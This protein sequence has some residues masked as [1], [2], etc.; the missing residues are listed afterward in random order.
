MTCKETQSL[1]MPY[2]HQELTDEKM[3][4]FLEHIETCKDCKE[5]LEIYYTVEVGIRQLDTDNG[6]YNIKGTMESDIF[7]SKQRLATLRIL[8]IIRYS[9]DTL[10]LISLVVTLMLQCRIWWQTGI[11]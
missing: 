3:D 11:F 5:E 9:A 6:N 7:M 10:T 8:N 1:V 2:I 4:E